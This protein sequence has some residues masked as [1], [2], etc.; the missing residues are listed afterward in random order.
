M[1]KSILHNKAD[2]TCYL[3]MLLKNDY[4]EKAGLQEH[5]I[6]FGS[7]NRKISEKYGLKVYLCLWHHT[8]GKE[9][10]HKNTEHDTLL[11]QTAQK[12]FIAKYSIELFM[13]KFRKN[14]LDMPIEEYTG[15][16]DVEKDNAAA[17][18]IFIE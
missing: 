15:S 1:A 5:H 16:K 9:A 4:S 11:K 8:E 14:Y 17:G 12:A 7:A 13:E 2:K 18:I 3:C 10:V 6:F